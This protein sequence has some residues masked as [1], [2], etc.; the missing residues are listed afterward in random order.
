MQ[1]LTSLAAK[2]G[3]PLSSVFK[4]VDKL[5]KDGVIVKNTCILD[6]SE[7]SFNCKVGLFFASHEKDEVKGLI[8]NHPNLNTLLRLSGDFDYYAEFVFSNMIEA[9]KA[10]DEL[11]AMGI[12]KGM[13]VH[14]VEDV[15][16]EEF[17]IGTC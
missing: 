15:K 2:A 14:F 1:S 8:E 6:F 7:M 4:D 16:R 5:Y 9:E 10:T 3:L 11:K 13:K 12:L 17:R